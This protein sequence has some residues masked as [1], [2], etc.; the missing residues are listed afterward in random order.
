LN[1]STIKIYSLLLMII[2]LLSNNLSV[3]GEKPPSFEYIVVLRGYENRN[4]PDIYESYYKNYLIT[5]KISYTGSKYILDFQRRCLG[6]YTYKNLLTTTIRSTIGTE[7]YGCGE[8]SIKRMFDDLSISIYR[9]IDPTFILPSIY[10]GYQ[11]IDMDSFSFLVNV[12]KVFEYKGLPVINISTVHVFTGEYRGK[13]VNGFYKTIEYLYA[14]LPFPVYYDINWTLFIDGEVKFNIM[15]RAEL[16]STD[17]PGIVKVGIQDEG[18]YVLIIG[19]FKDVNIDFKV[20]K[21][22]KDSGQNIVIHMD[23]SGSQYGY[24]MITYRNITLLK[25]YRP[26]MILMKPP[27]ELQVIKPNSEAELIVPSGIETIDI[28]VKPTITGHKETS[29]SYQTSI[30]SNINTTNVISSETCV[31]YLIIIIVLTAGALSVT[32]YL[33][34]QIS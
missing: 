19:G 29:S 24:I 12:S 18:E 17:L 27:V 22:S 14:G 23:N 4:I 2:F 3:D 30:N 15:F 7:G 33:R 26:N 6:G 21:T 25:D 20:T 28:T 5:Y 34:K 32:F 13:P 31:F 8:Y 16:E 10:T 9:V 1:I 11:G